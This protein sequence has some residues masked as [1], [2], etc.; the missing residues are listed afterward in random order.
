MR[1]IILVYVYHASNRTSLELKRNSD[2]ACQSDVAASNRTSLE[3]KRQRQQCGSQHAHA[4]NRTS[5]ELK[6]FHR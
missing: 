4:S 5:L 6:R 2:G 1:E 3:L